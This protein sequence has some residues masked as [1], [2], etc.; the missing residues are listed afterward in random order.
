MCN[1][2]GACRKESGV[3]CPSYMATA[4]EQDVTRGRATALR[5]ALSGQLGPGAFTSDALYE[6]LDL[7]VGCKACKRECPTGV[8]M[9]RM[10]TEFLY[11]YRKAHGY[12]L[13]DRIIGN[14][15]RS[16]PLLSRFGALV[17]AVGRVGP[18]KR[19]LGFSPQR[20]VPRWAARPFRE[21]AEHGDVVLFVDTFGRYFEPQVVRSAMRVLRAAGYSPILPNPG[22]PL[23]CGRTYLSTGMLEDARREMERVYDALHAHAERGLPIVGLEPSCLLT[24]RDE[25]VAVLGAR[26]QGIAQRAVLLEEFLAAEARAGRLELALGPVPYRRALV[27]GHCHQKALGAFGAVP[28][29]LKRIPSL[30]IE[31]ID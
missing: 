1:S 12:R 4:D 7:C 9:A 23:C 27:H 26:A 29:V 14:L 16:A 5:L 10:K 22:R 3:M 6:T 2:N 31:V 24:L 13:R 8:D 28:E 19:A 21:R 15:P 17:N 11:H 18:A 20:S 25:F 30:T